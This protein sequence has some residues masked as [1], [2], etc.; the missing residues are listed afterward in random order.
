MTNVFA[1]DKPPPSTDFTMI[2][3]GDL[4]TPVFVCGLS[5]SRIIVFRP[6]FVTISDYSRTPKE[7]LSVAFAAFDV[8]GDIPCAATI[9][10]KTSARPI[11]PTGLE[12][13]RRICQQEWRAGQRVGWPGE[14]LAHF[15]RRFSS[16]CRGEF[17]AAYC[18]P[19]STRLLQS[20]TPRF[21]ETC[22]AHLTT[23]QLNGL[24]H[25]LQSKQTRI[26]KRQEYSVPPRPQPRNN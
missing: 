23:R 20:F 1:E 25:A 22:T 11:R 16:E 5:A 21:V 15:P 10:V 13:D 8:A 4:Q 26:T 14:T 7:S 19:L 12:F 9:A 6:V 18:E 3:N 2:G 17:R 24:L